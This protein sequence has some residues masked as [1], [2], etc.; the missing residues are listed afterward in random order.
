MYAVMNKKGELFCASDV[1]EVK[2]DRLVFISNGEFVYG[3]SHVY[4]SGD[5]Y[6]PGNGH[7]VGSWYYAE[8]QLNV[9]FAENSGDLRQL[10]D[11]L[12]PYYGTFNIVT[13]EVTSV[14]WRV[15]GKND[16]YNTFVELI[17]SLTDEGGHNIKIEGIYNLYRKEKI[18]CNVKY[19]KIRNRVVEIKLFG[20]SAESINEVFNYF[21]NCKFTGNVNTIA[22][23]NGLFTE[24][25]TYKF[26]DIKEN[27]HVFKVT[28]RAS[29]GSILVNK[30][31]LK[32]LVDKYNKA[33]QRYKLIV[34]EYEPKLGVN[35]RYK[36]HNCHHYVYF[37]G[38]PEE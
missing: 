11:N 29:H 35:G 17:Y 9:S 14:R 1:Y 20:M 5:I 30:G 31:E 26:I 6:T 12:L 16:V 10:V 23:T 37:G 28:D 32:Q 2:G 13:K 4:K 33:Q 34:E 19:D 18:V 15:A 27:E 8:G 25:G 24:F 22:V 21:G 7:K 3:I 36:M 38:T